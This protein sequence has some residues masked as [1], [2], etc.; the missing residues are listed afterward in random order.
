MATLTGACVTA[1]GEK[2]AGL[3]TIDDGLAQKIIQSGEKTRERC[4]RM[5]LPEDYKE[6]VTFKSVGTDKFQH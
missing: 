6:L 4:W 5:P 2:I 3:F 1:L